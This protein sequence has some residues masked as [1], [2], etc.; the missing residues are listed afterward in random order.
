MESKVIIT[1]QEYKDLIEEN[2]DMSNENEWLYVQNHI[3]KNMVLE[4]SLNG[5]N[6]RNYSL[7]EVTD[8]NS[9][10]FGLVDPIRLFKVF[11][12]DEMRDY[13][14]KAKKNYEDEMAKNEE[15]ENERV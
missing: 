5:Y 9:F 4:T 13:I 6:I 7:E 12:L 15:A 14:I 10:H 2:H 3:L 11:T 1:A 8:I